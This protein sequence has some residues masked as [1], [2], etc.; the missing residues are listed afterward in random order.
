MTT[1][2][3]IANMLFW[4]G[5]LLLLPATSFIFISLLKYGL[6]LPYLFDSAEPLLESMGIKESFGFNINL[7]ILLGPVLA[8][9]LNLYAVVKIEWYNE[10][11]NFS[12]KVS[13][14]KHWWNMVLVIFS[15]LL[16]AFLF[17]YAIGEN[18]RC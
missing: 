1:S 12:A 4:F 17:I 3:N 7:L 16:L 15:G 5:A 10:K 2:V 11:E 18:C 6:G 13:V 9:L 14:Q 8:L